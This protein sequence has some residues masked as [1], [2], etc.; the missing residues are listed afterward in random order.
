MHFL[1][2]GFCGYKVFRHNDKFKSQK[3]ILLIW[4]IPKVNLGNELFFHRISLISIRGNYLLFCFE[5]F[6]LGNYLKV[7]QFHV[8][9]LTIFWKKGRETIQGNMVSISTFPILMSQDL[10]EIDTT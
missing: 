2:L 3:D 1:K 8:L 10:I 5:I 9:I 7:S 6:R 4:I